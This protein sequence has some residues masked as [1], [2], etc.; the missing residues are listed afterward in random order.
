MQVSLS[1]LPVKNFDHF[2]T[3][4]QLQRGRVQGRPQAE[5][6]RKLF[7]AVSG[8]SRAGSGLAVGDCLQRL[9]GHPEPRP[10]PGESEDERDHEQGHRGQRQV[11]PGE[12]VYQVREDHR[13]LKLAS[14]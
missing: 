7:V 11:L 5:P 1:H 9:E 2:E 13:L 4:L 3:G 14:G 12:V 6:L 8:R 10:R